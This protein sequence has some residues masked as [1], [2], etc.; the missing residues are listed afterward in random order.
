MAQPRLYIDE[1]S[2]S[3]GLLVALR[4]AAIDVTTSRESLQDGRPDN[5]QLAFAVMNQRVLYTRNVR[6]FRRLS[7]AYLREGRPH[8]GIIY[9]PAHYSIGEQLRRLINLWSARTLEQMINTEEYLS[10]WGEPRT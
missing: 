10:N 8:F 6:D 5:D 1:D 4:A 7:A 3:A 2:Q 9:W